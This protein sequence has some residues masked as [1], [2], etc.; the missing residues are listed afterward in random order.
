MATR[1]T[2]EQRETIVQFIAARTRTVVD[3]LVLGADE[4][5]RVIANA[6]EVGQIV[7]EE[8]RSVLRRLSVSAEYAS[9]EFSDGRGYPVEYRGPA[10]IQEQI[11]QIA[12]LF[13]ISPAKTLRFVEQTLPRLELPNGAEGW[14]AIPKVDAI[15]GRHFKSVTNQNERYCRA[16]LLGLKKLEESHQ[17][18]SYREGK[19]TPDMF[20]QHARTI[21]ML[22][23]IGKMQKGDILVIP[24]QFGLRHAGRSVRRG[25]AV[26][27]SS[28]FGHGTLAVGSMAFTHP[29]RFTDCKHPL[30]PC[31]S[32]DE[33]KP[34]PAASFDNT[35]IFGRVNGGVKFFSVGAGQVTSF[36]S[37]VSGFVPE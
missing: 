25:R 12:E 19:I 32:G 30:F 22:E 34:A 7:G 17:F 15:A 23:R 14:F 3:G 6:D 18:A 13:G 35:P 2:S 10:P 1:I 26:F 8:T 16:A 20:H 21:A 27:S 36:Y 4:A 37:S 31:C 5:E 28:E 11:I 24:S 33:F 9:E 29:T